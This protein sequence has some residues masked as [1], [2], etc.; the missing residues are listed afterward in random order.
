MS[1]RAFTRDEAQQRR[2]GLSALVVVLVAGCNTNVQVD[3]TGHRCTDADLCGPGF[4]CVDF[5]CRVATG[6][7][8]AGGGSVQS[9]GT[10]GGGALGGGTVVDSG[11]GGGSAC[12]ATSC[13]A[14]PA[15]ECVDSVARSFVGPGRCEP[16][17]GQCVFEA[18]E[19]DCAPGTCSN[20]TCSLTVTQT[21]PRV[22]FAVKAL[23]VA[24]GSAGSTVLVVGDRSQVSAWNGSSFTSIAAPAPNVALSAVN[25]TSQN[26]AWVLGANRTVW[27]WDR[28]SR[29][30]ISTPAPSNFSPT[31]TLIGVDGISDTLVLV[32]DDRGGW[33]KWNGV[34]WASGT[35]PT[36]TASGFT[37]S[38]VWVDEAQ[39]ERIAGSCLNSSGARRSCVAYRNPLST[40]NPTVWFVDVEDT[41][42]RACQS[43]G[44]WVDVPVSGGQ[45]A[46]CGYADTGSRRHT[47]QGNF[48]ASALTLPT[49]TGIVGITGGAPSAG[50]RPVWVLT[51][52]AQ[53]Q[54]R[55]YRLSG[56]GPSVT[57]QLDTLMGEGRLSASESGGVLVA[58][59]TATGS[60]NNIFY[61]RTTPT[62]RTDALDLGLDFAGVTSLAGELTLVSNAG[63]LAVQHAGS[64]VFEFRRPQS[65]SP[66]YHVE[67]A[68]G[69]N[70]SA[71]LVVGRDG[72]NAGLI[73][74]VSFSGYTRLTTT[75]PA[76]TFKGVCRASDTEA[77]AV[78]TGGAV[79]SIGAS[80]ATREPTVTTVNELLDVDCP[81]VG[82]AVACGANS[83]VLR[84]T[85]SGVWADV[86]FPMAG[87][88]FTSCRLVNG[89][90]WAAGDNVFAR[91]DR[92]SSTWVV[93][94]AAPR[95]SNLVVRAPNDVLATSA[96][97]STVDV[98]RYDGSRWNPMLSGISGSARGGVQVGA[99]VV[100]GGP[101]GL[102]VEGR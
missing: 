42:T 38:S 60:A 59:N 48:V 37:M 54:G 13:T 84:R 97:A 73:S 70:G 34:S 49:G 93:L 1:T 85:P 99:R 100:W 7:G 25:F 3:P 55:L 43:V 14:V 32:A 102:L 50:T 76:T 11:M 80:S 47:T 6:G 22:R 29:A 94:N 35:L 46:L 61:R 51:G 62:E 66:Q 69:R 52:A 81:V 12:T 78:G 45:D 9:G 79:F 15:A 24:P 20:G 64:D 68:D 31:S 5:V 19:L 36:T 8:A 72:V 41:D 4:Q 39:R 56:S 88:T 67:D 28:T 91:L 65:A 74:R 75:A 86:S 57:P 16:S 53:G 21:G 17:T 87:V 89:A 92:G 40:T 90:I 18:F 44:P 26:T 77:W 101:S 82:Q 83:T 98:L 95:L 27:R 30:F 58:E 96:G 2:F 63:D 10:G 71:V 23:D 33:A